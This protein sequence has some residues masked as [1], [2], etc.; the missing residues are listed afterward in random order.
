MFWFDTPQHPGKASLSQQMTGLDALWPM[1][2]G[3]TVLDVG[4]A[5][6]LIGLEC[7]KRGARSVDGIEIRPEAAEIARGHGINIIGNNV[8]DCVPRKT[9]D[10]ILMLG[11]LN[12]LKRPR[13]TFLHFADA[14]DEVCVLRL[15][16]GFYEKL[17]VMVYLSGLHL[18]KT[19]NG[20]EVAGSAPQWVGYL[21][22]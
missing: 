22:R 7:L 14:C 6:G 11:I 10:V 21:S 19:C 2:V 15:P 12:K 16:A 17:G 18:T 5:E 4:C 1:V 9:Y 8:E 20:P 13:R 3:K